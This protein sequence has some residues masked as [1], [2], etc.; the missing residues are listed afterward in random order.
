MSNKKLPT[1]NDEEIKSLIEL[2]HTKNYPD[3]EKKAL[4][5]INNDKENF[6]AFNLL[7]LAKSSQNK[8]EDAI[9]TFDKAISI[10]EDY[11]PAHN[12][13]G[14]ILLKIKNFS[15]AILSFKKAIKYEKNSD[16]IQLNLGNC[17]F[18]NAQYKE[19]INTYEILIK[20]N[21]KFTQAYQA[22]AKSQSLLKEYKKSDDAYYKV[23]EIENNH[24]EAIIGISNNLFDI[25]EYEKANN[26]ISEKI[27]NGVENEK[28]YFNNGYAYQKRREY[29]LAIKEYD[30]IIN[31][32]KNYYDAYLNLSF[33]FLALSNKNETIKNLEKVLEIKP[34]HKLALKNLGNALLSIG[35]YKQAIDYFK[36][37]EDL[38]TSDIDILLSSGLAYFNQSN[39]EDAKRYYNKA[40]KINKKSYQALKML[41]EISFIKGNYKEAIN[42]FEQSLLIDDLDEA[43]T[44]YFYLGILYEKNNDYERSLLNFEESLYDDGENYW[45]ENYLRVLYKMEDNKR[46]ENTLGELIEENRKSNILQSIIT[47]AEINLKIKNDYDFCNNAIEL[48]YKKSVADSFRNLKIKT[49][50]N[51]NVFLN[52]ETNE[53]KLFKEDV[54]ES[55]KEYKQSYQPK[56]IGY[57]KDFETKSSP[58]FLPSI[59][60]DTY[61]EKTIIKNDLFSGILFLSDSDSA[62]AIVF[63]TSGDNYPDNSKLYPNK[64]LK[65]KNGDLIFYPSSLFYTLKLSDGIKGSLIEIK[66][67]KN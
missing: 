25:K 23:L 17:Y 58:I 26:F 49:H 34:D 39:L 21:N 38:D 10:K 5:I 59:T 29:K 62:S 43:E 54:S 67:D 27:K 15:E 12:N 46:F 11:A 13:R 14:N 30:K 7:G 63:K 47:H 19:A 57:F 66:I 53:I 37:F 64:T 40:L 20:S 48:I 56:N 33:C 18:S 28:V 55:F 41:G 65:I 52:S 36:K 22:L 8:N 9:R 35:D 42:E 24:I 50:D 44:T 61:F 32:N 45:K 4:E 1:A 16:N 51:L 2:Y 60:N 3:L 31:L 6:I